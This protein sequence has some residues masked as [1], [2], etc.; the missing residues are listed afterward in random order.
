MTARLQLG[1]ERVHK[2]VLNKLLYTGVLTKP[3]LLNLRRMLFATA[4]VP[5]YWCDR[6]SIMEA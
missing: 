1:V 2:D 5:Q 6:N 3:F 4:I